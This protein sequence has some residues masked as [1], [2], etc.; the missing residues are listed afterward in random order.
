MIVATIANGGQVM[1]PHLMKEI[2]GQDLQPIETTQPDRLG[3]AIA[4]DVAAAAQRPDGEQRELHAGNG[5]ITG[6]QIAAKTG[7]AE[8][9]NDPKNTPP[10]VWYVAFAPADD[11]QVAVAVI[12]ENGGDPTTWRPP[13]ALVA[14]PIGRA[15]SSP[16]RWARRRDDRPRRRSADRRPLPARPPDRGRRHGRGLGGVGHPAGPQRRG[17]VLRP[18]L[19]DDPEFLHRFRTEARTVRRSTTPASPRCTTTARTRAPTGA[20]RPTW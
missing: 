16:R 19:T 1:A 17:E 5:K 14:A 4:A 11:P 7:T 13:A 20:A 15:P 10:H 9:G 2:Q 12:V 3:R 18:E 8:H 6:V